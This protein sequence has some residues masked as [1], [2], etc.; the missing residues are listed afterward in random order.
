MA[1]RVIGCNAITEPLQCTA[2]NFSHAS[3]CP[4]HHHRSPHVDARPDNICVKK[5]LQ[6]SQ[7]A[8]L[9]PCGCLRGDFVA[10]SLWILTT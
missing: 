9:H 7:P 6:T 1:A 5:C 8:T 3:L 10:F 4:L 2:P